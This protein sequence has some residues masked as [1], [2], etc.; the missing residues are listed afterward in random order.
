MKGQYIISNLTREIHNIK[1]I[2]HKLIKHET[3][4]EVEM[5]DSEGYVIDYCVLY[6]DIR[7]LVQNTSTINLCELQK[8]VDDLFETETE[9][10]LKAWVTGYN[11]KNK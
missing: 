7:K 3:F 10:S 9:E 8:A 11:K 5:L 2:P 4:T 1:D 6:D